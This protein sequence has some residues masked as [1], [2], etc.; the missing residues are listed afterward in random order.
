MLAL[1]G[2]MNTDSFGKLLVQRYAR[3]PFFHCCA[4]SSL[5]VK[6]ETRTLK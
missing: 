2:M 3:R 4:K 6:S 1:K 5:E